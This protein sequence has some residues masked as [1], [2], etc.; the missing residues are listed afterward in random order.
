MSWSA[1][2]IVT[3]LALCLLAFLMWAS[4]Y[5]QAGGGRTTPAA[6]AK[7][8][9]STLAGS[10]SIAIPFAN[11]DA[12]THCSSDSGLHPHAEHLYVTVKNEG[13]V[14]L[15]LEKLTL[16]APTDLELCEGTR[17]KQPQGFWSKSLDQEVVPGRAALIDLEIGLPQRSLTGTLPLI[18][19]ADV[20]GLVEDKIQTQAYLATD[21]VET[22]VP[23]VSDTLKLFGVPTVLL[24][25]GVLVLGM[26]SLIFVPKNGNLASPTSPGFW[27]VSIMASL[28]ISALYLWW[29]GRGPETLAD[30]I[31]RYEVADIVAL[32]MVSVG[33]GAA[34]GGV[35]LICRGIRK[36]CADR[37][38][39]KDLEK[40]RKEKEG[41][42]PTPG[43]SPRVL[44]ARLVKL[45]LSIP[46]RWVEVGGNHGFLVEDEGLERP[47][48]I[49]QVEVIQD[50]AA[51]RDTLKALDELCRE[52]H[53]AQTLSEALQTEALK[54]VKLDWRT[55]RPE[56]LSAN[57]EAKSAEP[58]PFIY[59]G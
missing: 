14:N 12:R 1:F 59:I 5:A 52:P 27:I 37:Q 31:D 28:V 21:K 18:L 8:E 33:L 36:W 41:N 55:G 47:W 23:G 11:L 29:N 19:R 38:L 48:L 26:M 42:T 51:T 44:I 7:E 57:Y 35:G 22:R 2:R 10:V 13:T 16:L 56:P 25:P 20:S 32:W 3:H 24:L 43:D 50:S 58:C 45:G 54:Q 30:L 39:Q 53:V 6:A 15:R 40:A 4:A 46:A 9:K 17:E 34:I 49:P